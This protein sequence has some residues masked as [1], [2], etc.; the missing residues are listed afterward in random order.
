MSYGAW[1][2]FAGPVDAGWQG[3]SRAP[4]RWR[5][6]P[7]LT[8]RRGPAGLPASTKGNPAP[9]SGGPIMLRWPC[10]PRKARCRYRRSWP[11][12]VRRNRE[13]P[14]TASHRALLRPRQAGQGRGV[15]QLMSDGTIEAV[16]D[17]DAL[18]VGLA[19][20]ASEPVQFS[21]QAVFRLRCRSPVHVGFDHLGVL[22]PN[23]PKVT[24]RKS[25]VFNE[26]LPSHRDCRKIGGQAAIAGSGTR[27][28]AGQNFC[29]KPE[30]SV[31]L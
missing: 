9:R 2:A 26:L 22:V 1:R 29:P 23:A 13:T 14:E 31:P 20:L 5:E 25:G 15:D 8:A 27:S 17:D 18:A 3:R 10:L 28:L 16:T 24:L 19:H 7:A 21:A 30:R 6:A 4:A 12:S 11:A